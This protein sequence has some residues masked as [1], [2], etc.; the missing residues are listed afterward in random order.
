MRPVLAFGPGFV[1]VCP[2]GQMRVWMD[3]EGLMASKESGISQQ[4]Q[5][6]VM[7]C[8]RQPEDQW[9]DQKGIE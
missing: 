6:G 8:N 1:R 7:G 5:Q 4:C 9:L 3:A 2:Q